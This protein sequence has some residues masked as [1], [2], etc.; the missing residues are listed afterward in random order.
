MACAQ[1]SEAPEQLTP[2]PKKSEAQ[3]AKTGGGD[4]VATATATLSQPDWVW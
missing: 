4:Q 1:P 3:S 2:K